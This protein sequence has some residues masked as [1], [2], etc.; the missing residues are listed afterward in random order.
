VT[1]ITLG[2]A[3][4][5]LNL[6]SA[7]IYVW[8]THLRLKRERQAAYIKS[9]VGRGRTWGLEHEIWLWEQK[10]KRMRELDGE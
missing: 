9:T 1:L 4:I 6:I 5:V 8:R 7:T 3:A 10:Q 2:F